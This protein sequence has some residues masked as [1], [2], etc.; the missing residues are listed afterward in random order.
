M[1]VKVYSA[2]FGASTHFDQKSKSSALRNL[3]E[4]V[5]KV[6]GNRKKER[7]GGEDTELEREKERLTCFQCTRSLRETA[8]REKEKD[9][10]EKEREKQESEREERERE[11]G[12]REKEKK[13]SEGSDFVRKTGHK[14]CVKI[15]LANIFQ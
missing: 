15:L 7:R 14:Q 10:K 2:I 3:V 8:K 9:R 13:E 6:T 12:K 11:T 1:R 4:V 5:S